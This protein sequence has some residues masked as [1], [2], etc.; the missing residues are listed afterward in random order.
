MKDSVLT[1]LSPCTPRSLKTN[2]KVLLIT[3]GLALSGCGS[4][5]P[6]CDSDDTLSLVGQIVEEM[7]VVRLNNIRFVELKDEKQLGFNEDKE[8][9]SCSATLVTSAGEDSIYY[10]VEWDDKD[11]NEFWVE[12]EIR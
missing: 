3:A 7:P 2:A 9:R 5:L 10:T 4:S 11:A 6:E 12:A 8:L 1:I